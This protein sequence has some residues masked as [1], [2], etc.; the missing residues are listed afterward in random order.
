MEMELFER[1]VD[2]AAESGVERIHCYLHGEPFLHPE[3]PKMLRYM[4]SRNLAVHLTT[5]GSALD[6]QKIRAVLSAGLDFGD[7]IIFSVLGN[8]KES[9]ERIMRGVSHERVMANI[10]DFVSMR[11]DLRKNG[12]IFETIL[13]TMKE[14]QDEASAF[15]QFWR[16][17]VDHARVHWASRSFATYKSDENA[18]FSRR[19]TCPQI[20]ER[21]TI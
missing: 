18:D 5:N 10:G 8:S 17:K 14:N 3:L 4:K 16:G 12:P 1:I 7:H 15:L 13:Y 2:E 11:R 20:W 19:D 9:H 6:K 21:L